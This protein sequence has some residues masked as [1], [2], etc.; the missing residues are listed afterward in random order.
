MIVILEDIVLF[1]FFIYIA[2]VIC[3]NLLNWHLLRLIDLRYINDVELFA[4]CT[5]LCKQ[6]IERDISEL[7]LDVLYRERGIQSFDALL[8][9]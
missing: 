3:D 2:T 5:E 7:M 8:G 9:I 4:A 1:L 6:I